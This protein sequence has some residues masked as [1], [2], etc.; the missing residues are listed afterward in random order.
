MGMLIRRLKQRLREGGRKAPFRCIATSATIT[1]DE[2]EEDK[3]TVAK[4]ATELFDEEFSTNG[5]I[6]GEYELQKTQSEIRRFHMFVRALEGAFLTYR[7]GKDV[8]I[9]NRTK[10]EMAGDLEANP[11]EIALCKECGQHYYVGHINSHEEGKLTEA[12]R[13]PSRLDFGVDYYLPLIEQDNSSLFLCRRCGILSS[14]IVCT[15]DAMIPVKKCNSRSEHPD[16]LSKCEVCDYRRGGIGDPVQEIVHGSDGPNAVIA[17]A[18]H[19]LLPENGR[20]ILAFADSRQ[21]AAFLHGM[22]KTPTK[23]C[24]TVIR[25]CMPCARRKPAPE[26]YPL[27]ISKS[28]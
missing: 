19:G 27:M 23:N 22:C 18:L 5:I 10:P 1:S 7:D 13:D 2:R 12:V 21:E 11:L 20:K 8:V 25:Y 17:T 9:L 28:D 26:A 3:K 15:C 16:Q 14:K 24:T 6:F 4:F